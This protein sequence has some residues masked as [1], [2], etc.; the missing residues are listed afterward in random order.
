MICTYTS[1]ITLRLSLLE[2]PH[3]T[4]IA[5]ITSLIAAAFT[6]G[7]FSQLHA[8][9]MVI[10]IIARL[11]AVLLVIVSPHQSNTVTEHAKRSFTRGRVCCYQIEITERSENIRLLAMAQCPSLEISDMR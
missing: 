8:H 10:I 2:T 3:G 11:A 7:T 1:S 9:D 6:V 5:A 4:I